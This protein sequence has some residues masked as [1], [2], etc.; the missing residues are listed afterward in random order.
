MA[1]APPIASIRLVLPQFV[2]APKT[3]GI[4]Y[5]HFLQLN[6]ISPFHESA[7]SMN[8]I[9]V[10][11]SGISTGGGRGFAVAGGHPGT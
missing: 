8:I 10:S 3:R 11:A 1:Q 6:C 4:P 5:P 2:H 9:A 7:G